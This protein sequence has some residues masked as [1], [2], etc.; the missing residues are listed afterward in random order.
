MLRP[1]ILI[2]LST[3]LASAA[4][5]RL[6]GP[7]GTVELH[8][9]TGSN[10]H[11]VY[12]ILQGGKVRF[13]EAS[14]GIWVDGADLGAGAVLGG[15][16]RRS[17]SETFPWRGGKAIGTNHCEAAEMD[18]RSGGKAWVLEARVFEDGAA[19]RYRV[20][21][22]GA[23]AVRGESTRWR[24]PADAKVWFQ[25][26]TGDYEGEYHPAAADAIP[27]VEGEKKTPVHLGPPI[28]LEYGDGVLGLVSEAAL[29]KYSGLTLR[30]LGGREL[31]AAFQDDPRG[32]E[33]QG[34]VLSPWR[35]FILSRDLG[36]L[37]N[38]DVIP[39]LCDPPDPGLFPEGPNSKWLSTG[40]GPCTWMVYGNDGAQWDR[41]KWFVDVAAATGCEYLLVDAGWRSEKW[42]WLKGGGDVWARA[43]EL[44][45]YARERR[46]G[47]ILWHAY[48][49]GRDDSPGLTTPES[50]EELFA[51]CAQAGVTGLKIDFFNSESR[52]MIGAYEDLLRRS[53]KH[54]LLIN[55]HGANKPTGEARTWPNEITR[56]GIREQEY[57]LWGSLPLEHYG[58]LP[59]TRMAAGHGD[60][61]PGY[62]QPKFLK[63][64][65]VMFQMASTIV[66]TS[67]F[68]CW[69]DN[70]E[71]YL[72]SPLLQF[73]RTVPVT[74]DETRVLPG[75]KIGDL[76][77]LARRKGT[78]WHVAALN[79]R[80]EPREVELDLSFVNFEG[81][82]ITSYQDGETPGG[83]R[84]DH[85]IG[86]P[87]EKIRV[88]LQPGGGGMV[89]ILARR[90]FSGWK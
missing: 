23:R 54:R 19:F 2:A 76:V 85:G 14:A 60:F 83:A 32:W 78:D 40:K 75:T 44:C 47:I 86:A 77:V 73:I 72:A 37:V 5:L 55:F 80:G 63:N 58:A 48:P 21:G 56:E 25:T 64:T 65:T 81:K 68:L 34:E 28:T 59:F 16:R 52:A 20:P 42:G 6:G 13:E 88:T 61:L 7:S 35:V 11:L 57:V 46:V 84:I 70:P 24:L 41:Q 38:C 17:I 66:F 90:E 50:R 49:E 39:A 33:E 22:S 8:F 29:Y 62:V 82:V 15:V 3:A 53:A 74:W 1:L 71:A 30:P 43:A 45:Q 18:I 10:G 31:E 36:G 79:C 27:Q 51:K 89:Q 67:P 87:V 4:G 9:T 26:N 69:P 12:S